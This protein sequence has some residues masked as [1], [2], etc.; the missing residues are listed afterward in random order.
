MVE[1]TGK[2]IMV[3][4]SYQLLYHDGCFLLWF[5][6]SQR[7]LEAVWKEKSYE[8]G[9]VLL[10]VAKVSVGGDEAHQRYPQQEGIPVNR[11]G[12]IVK[13]F[14]FLCLL[15]G[16]MSVPYR[17][18]DGNLES[19]KVPYQITENWWRDIDTHSFQ[20]T[21]DLKT[22]SWIT[23]AFSTLCFRYARKESYE[24]R[25]CSTNPNSGPVYA[26][27]RY[28][29]LHVRLAFGIQLEVI[30]DQDDCSCILCSLKVLPSLIHP[31]RDDRPR[32]VEPRTRHL[33]LPRPSCSAV[34]APR[35]TVRDGRRDRSFCTTG[36]V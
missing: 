33:H 20:C 7:H 1:E 19:L 5:Q 34:A 36:V 28:S 8:N 32:T 35:E 2:T 30:N 3:L 24:W 6:R 13:L 26:T 14:V 15:I 27:P 18:G 21:E 31:T 22:V 23:T 9:T 16:C 11:N 10:R 29:I 4:E 12:T 17:T 25:R